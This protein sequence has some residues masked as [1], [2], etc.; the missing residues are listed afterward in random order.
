MLGIIKAR[1]ARASI[2]KPNEATKNQSYISASSHIQKSHVKIK[3]LNRAIKDLKDQ[4]NTIH[5][6][7]KIVQLENVLSDK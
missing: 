3:K 2:K 7:P 1:T 4:L 6:L 5:E